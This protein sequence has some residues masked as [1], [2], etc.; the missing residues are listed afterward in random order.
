MS[1]PTTILD[2]GG[3]RLTRRDV[4]LGG[5]AALLLLAGRRPAAAK[6]ADV[7]WRQ[8]LS[9]PRAWYGGAE[10]ARL[11]ESVL[12]AQHA[13]GGWAKNI[14]W[15]QPLSPD[16]RKTL[17]E[18]KN[19]TVDNGATHREAAFLARIAGETSD[20]GLRARCRAATLRALDWLLDAQ[21]ANGG[22]PQ[23]WPDPKGYQSRITFNDDA[24]AGVLALLR[25]VARGA[26]DYAFVDA[27]HRAR[28]THAVEKG[29]DCTL[30][31]QIRVDGR[32]TVWCAQHDEKTFAPAPA[33]I[34]EKAS[35]SGSESVGIVRFL[36][37]VEKPDA[38]V[39]EAIEGAVA[40]FER[41]KL[42]GIAVVRKEDPTLPGGWDR[43]V[44][45]DKNAPPVWARFYDLKTQQPIFCGRDGVVKRTLAEIEHERRTGYAWYTDRPAS[46]LAKDYP[47][48]RSRV[49][50]HS[51]NA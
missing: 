9:Q 31:C 29:I 17:A 13:V 6:R 25:D 26:A 47:A 44:V 18:A 12:A 27:S 24:M 3:A 10:A 28:C 4:A 20:P 48:W 22:W 33:R 11:A 14:D 30:R 36:M 46:L 40:W 41:A 49:S 51:S 1:K 21:Y 8:A 23:F 50:G 5:A 38:R 37:G 39:R 15:A 16:D 34:Y 43:V 45:P 2:V 32:P 19:A 42:T 35:F 7:S